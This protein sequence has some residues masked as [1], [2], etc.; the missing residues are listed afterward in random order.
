[1]WQRLAPIHM[2]ICANGVS[3]HNAR[4]ATLCERSRMCR[5]CVA[6]TENS[7][8]YRTLTLSLHL[9]LSTQLRR[10]VH[11]IVYLMVHNFSC[12]ATFIDLTDSHMYFEEKT[13]H[14]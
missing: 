7:T 5:L 2:E 13:T 12:V 1:M 14:F 8:K 6:T 11:V 9:P 3:Y 10:R 4:P